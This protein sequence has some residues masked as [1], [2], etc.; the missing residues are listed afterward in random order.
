MVVDAALAHTGVAILTPY[1][2]ILNIKCINTEK[3]L[4]K[5]KVRACDDLADR[6]KYIFNELVATAKDN[7]VAVIAA[8][9]PSGGSKSLVAGRAMGMAIAI[10]ACVVEAT[11][12][13]NIWVT[14][15]EGKK[16]L[17]GKRNASKADI[18]KAAFIAHPELTKLVPTNKQGKYPSWIE[19]VCDA[20]AV[21]EVVKNDPIIRVIKNQ[22]CKL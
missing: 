11:K 5:R 6:A 8:E 13:P 14:P 1:G 18:Q 10:L 2:K 15:S 4:T 12:L 9:L 7:D 16:A 21:W 19:H 3:D 22:P 17:G 20:L